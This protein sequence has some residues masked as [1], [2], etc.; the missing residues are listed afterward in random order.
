M[1]RRLVTNAHGFATGITIPNRSRAHSNVAATLKMPIVAM[2]I[3]MGSRITEKGVGDA[4]SSSSV[5][6]QRSSWS[7]L[8]AVVAIAD[9]IPMAAAPRPA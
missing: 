9:Q 2:A 1:T 5:P 8:L 3:A 7:M 6:A 4:T